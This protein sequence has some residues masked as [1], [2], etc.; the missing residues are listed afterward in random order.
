MKSDVNQRQQPAIAG[1]QPTVFLKDAGGRLLQQLLIHLENPTPN[2]LQVEL[3]CSGQETA[4]TLPPGPSTHP[5]FI[6]E[7]LQASTLEVTLRVGGSLAATASCAV[8]P[9]RHWRVHVVQTSHHDAG[10]TDLPTRVLL[11]HD[12]WLAQALDFAHETRD[13]P[14]SAQFRISIEQAWSLDHFL[15]NASTERAKHMLQLLRCGQFELNPLFGNMVSELCGHETLVRALYHSAQLSRQH[16][17]PLLC[18]EHNDIP[19]FS[20]GLA[21]LLAQAG[22][23]F[24]C[25]GLPLYYDW[26]TL[27]LQ[28]FWDQASIF[29]HPGPGAFWWE[30]ISGE[31]LLFYCN[32]SG[33]GGDSRPELPGLASQ[34]QQWEEANTPYSVVRWPVIGAERDNSPYHPGYSQTVRAW[35]EQWAYPH[36]VCST[37]AAFYREFR[38]QLPLDLPTWRGELPGQDYPSGATSTAHPT[39]RNRGNH[40]LAPSAEKLAAFT[41]LTGALEYP[42]ALLRQAYTEILWHDEHT[43]GYHFPA[44]P[45]AEAAEAEKALHA[46]HAAA[47]T[48]E[49]IQKSLAALADA[50]CFEQPGNY[51]LVFNPTGQERS[52]LLRAPLR[53]FDNAGSTILPAEDGHLHGVLLNR[54]WHANLP[55]ETISGAFDLVD[56]LSGEE[57]PYQ[58]DCI[59]SPRTPLPFAAHRLG[60]GLGSRRYGLFEDPSGIRKDLCFIAQHIPAYGYKVYWLRPSAAPPAFSLALPATA[61]SIENEFFRIHL[62]PDGQSIAEIL[63]KSTGRNLVDS[64][65]PHPFASLVVRAPQQDQEDLLEHHAFQLVA[66]GTVCAAFEC[67]GS[68]LGHPQVTTRLSLYAGVP[69]L[70][71]ETRL[72][73]DSTP[74]LTLH[75]A[76]PFNIPQPHFRYEGV[77]GSIDPASDLLPGAYSDVLAVQN[78]VQVAGSGQALLWSSLDAPLASLGGLWP[79]YVSPAHRAWIDESARHAPLQTEDPPHGWIYAN[80]CNNNFGTNFAVSQTGDL[81]FRFAITA[82]RQPF[83]DSEAACFG[84]QAVTP[85]E[86][87]FTQ[88]PLKF[89]PPIHLPACASFLRVDPPGVLALTL[90]QAEDGS[91][92]ILRLWNTAA[93]AQTAQVEFPFLRIQAAFL[94]S[95]TE[96]AQEQL[97][98]GQPHSLALRL[99]AQGLVTLRLSLDPLDPASRQDM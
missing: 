39:A 67:Q 52:D 82:R 25:P 81:L 38:S 40:T 42:S 57:I 12:A 74:L 24:F 91:A 72:F 16:S 62:S 88:R 34:L 18:A 89:S 93:A 33:C 49:V 30:A 29:R 9:P 32:N 51:L 79:G 3:A 60:L 69:R 19:G 86:P 44:G 37:N 94:A 46:Y 28:S 71:I 96:D 13:F 11:Q 64:D 84:Q 43:W 7:P 78:W 97:K 56:A 47:Y 27:K 2:V 76:F 20:W 45:A 31:R 14:Q 65:C 23:H 90:K 41:H 10:Y 87:M 85:L 8:R 77:L 66:A 63:D 36:L 83:S 92:W 55:S 48:H 95:I 4:F 98:V 61:H 35:N 22:I 26:G 1:I 73:K 50:A 53:A 70:F 68:L 59:D 17:F 54:R 15:K 99:A 75:Q 6:P 80:L 21:R 58:I 5:I